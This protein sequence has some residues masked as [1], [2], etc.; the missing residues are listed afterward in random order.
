MIGLRHRGQSPNT[1]LNDKPL[2]CRPAKRSSEG[3]SPSRSPGLGC[4]E[5]GHF[6][7]GDFSRR[8]INIQPALTLR[9]LGR[10]AVSIS[11]AV[12]PR[13]GLSPDSTFAT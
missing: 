13:T 5:V 3:E 12:D 9:V 11:A 10:P 2:S 1:T 7:F 4:V 6:H 8:W